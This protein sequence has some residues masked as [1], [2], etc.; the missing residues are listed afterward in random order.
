MD[1]CISSMS[2]RPRSR[3]GRDNVVSDVALTSE[4][5][6]PDGVIRSSSMNI[7]LLI[8]EAVHVN[9]SETWDDANA[10]QSN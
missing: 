2:G 7:K 3:L 9:A 10:S 6:S 4:E 1:R 5:L 8:V